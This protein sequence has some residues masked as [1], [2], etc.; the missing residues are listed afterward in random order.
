MNRLRLEDFAAPAPQQPAAAPPEPPDAQDIRLNAYEEGYKAGWDD[1][2][3]AENEEHARVSADFAKT[4]QEMSF[5]YH[6]ARAHVLAALGPLLTAMVERVVPHIASAGFAR[7][8]VETAMQMA[9]AEANRPVRLRI[10]PDNREALDALI[11]EDPGLPLAIVDDDTVG[12]G[13]ALVS[14]TESECEIDIDGMLAAIQT[15]LD[16]F[17]KTEEEARRHG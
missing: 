9:E 6:E 16:E 17:L 11:G 15:A 5:S 13:Q 3:A 1:A 4:L 12:P 10:N 2:A 14:G 8:V 7:T